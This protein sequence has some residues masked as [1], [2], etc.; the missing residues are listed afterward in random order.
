M[1]AQ[2]SIVC[3][4]IQQVMDVNQNSS[5]QFSLRSCTIFHQS[6]M[7]SSEEFIGI[8]LLTK[9]KYPQSYT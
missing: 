2:E 9:R 1:D 8:P 5:S 3:G 7:S 6:E 4:E